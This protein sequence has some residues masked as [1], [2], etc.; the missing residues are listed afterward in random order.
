MGDYTW[1]PMKCSLCDHE[2]AA[3]SIDK[4]GRSKPQLASVLNHLAWKHK[5]AYG[6]LKD[7]LDQIMKGYVNGTN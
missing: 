7:I 3:I 2:Y 1:A 4:E 5:P 6:R